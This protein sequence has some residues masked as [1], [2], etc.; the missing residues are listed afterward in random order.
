MG[1][2]EEGSRG[3]E[4]SRRVCRDFTVKTNKTNPGK[5]VEIKGEKL[6]TELQSRRFRFLQNPGNV[7][8]NVRL[9]FTDHFNQTF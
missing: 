4:V 2:Y 6:R 3:Q 9:M 7:L 1:G 5:K 8:K